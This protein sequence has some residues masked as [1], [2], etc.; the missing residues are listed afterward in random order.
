MRIDDL[1]IRCSYGVNR[2]ERKLLLK[3]AKVEIT[4]K[5]LYDYFEDRTSGT[6]KWIVCENFKDIFLA[7]VTC[8][9][10]L[11]YDVKYYKILNW[12]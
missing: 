2:V 10:M 12:N 4:V 3:R 6:N 5:K 7:N 9:R 8:L 11:L 1:N